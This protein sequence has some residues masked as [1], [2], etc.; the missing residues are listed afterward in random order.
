MFQALVSTAGR[1]LGDFHRTLF[2]SPSLRA[3]LVETPSAPL[4][5]YERLERVVLTDAVSRTLFDE[6]AAHRDTQRGEEETGWVLLG[7]REVHEALVLAT[8]PAGWNA[9]P[10]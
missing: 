2:P 3:D 4:K 5:H 9:A 1:W 10:G 6:Y 7:V 8:M